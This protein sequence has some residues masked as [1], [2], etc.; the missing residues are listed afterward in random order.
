MGRWR[1]GLGMLLKGEVSF[2]LF[3]CWFGLVGLLC[4]DSVFYNLVFDR[5]YVYLRSCH[6]LVR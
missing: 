2:V 6:S 4:G 5:S 3:V 1:L